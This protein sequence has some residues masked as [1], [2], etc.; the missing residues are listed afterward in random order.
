MSDFFIQDDV[1]NRLSG[2]KGESNK[3]PIG[4]GD[5]KFICK[6]K[7]ISLGILNFTIDAGRTISAHCHWILWFSDFVHGQD[8]DAVDD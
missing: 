8:R 1:S 5:G 4:V 6:S 7:K 2:I 3:V